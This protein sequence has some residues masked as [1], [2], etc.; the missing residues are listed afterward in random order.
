MAEALN[1]RSFGGVHRR[2]TNLEKI[3]LIIPPPK[4]KMARSR[5]LSSLGKETLRQYG[6]L[7]NTVEE[8]AIVR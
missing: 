6:A 2:L 1:L 4:A 8:S 7:K 3:G 5:E